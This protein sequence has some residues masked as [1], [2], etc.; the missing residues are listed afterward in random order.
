MMT[1]LSLVVKVMVPL[2][3]PL[4]PQGQTLPPLKI[5]A[6]LQQPVQKVQSIKFFQYIYY[7]K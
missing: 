6:L 3:Q 5:M 1:V 2:H 7:S 4:R